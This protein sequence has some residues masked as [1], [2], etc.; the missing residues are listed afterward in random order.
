[1]PHPTQA[2]LGWGTRFFHSCS[3]QFFVLVSSRLFILVLSSAV[4]DG[5]ASE[6][7]IQ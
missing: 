6:L 2:E 3:I 5:H 1:M 7:C 4:E